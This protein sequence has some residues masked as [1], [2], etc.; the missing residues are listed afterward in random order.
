M[1]RVAVQIFSAVPANWARQEGSSAG[2]TTACTQAGSNRTPASALTQ[3]SK[4]H[5]HCRVMESSVE[6]I[7]RG[8]ERGSMIPRMHSTILLSLRKCTLEMASRRALSVMAEIKGDAG[9]LDDMSFLLSSWQQIK[10]GWVMVQKYSVPCGDH[11]NSP[12][13][14]QLMWFWGGLCAAE[15]SRPRL[16]FH[17]KSK[18]TATSLSFPIPLA[19]RSAQIVSLSSQI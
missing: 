12:V 15:A 19:R 17:V 2:S 5:P 1:L 7:G 13:P 11:I 14:L 6:H 4:P 3:Q 16:P 10:L 18:S 9:H 8:W